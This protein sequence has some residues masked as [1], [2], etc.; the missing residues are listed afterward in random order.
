M[1]KN[2]APKTKRAA[3]P[4]TVTVQPVTRCQ[5]CRRP[6]TYPRLPGA[7]AAALTAHYAREHAPVPAG[8]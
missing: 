8:A 1:S 7:A 5:E 4:V 2:P 3:E 6:V